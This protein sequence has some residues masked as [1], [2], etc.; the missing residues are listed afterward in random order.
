MSFVNNDKIATVLKK[1]IMS[2]NKENIETINFHLSQI[3]ETKN[4]NFSELRNFVS[5]GCVIVIKNFI[6]KSMRLEI[7]NKIYKIS[8]EWTS[9][10][11][12]ELHCIGSVWYCCAASNNE[13]DYFAYSQSNNA[14]LK[15]I[16]PEINESINS[17]CSLF[18]DMN[19]EIRE[20]WAGP[21]IIIL[22]E[23]AHV[24][25]Q[26]GP[27][28]IDW[29]NLCKEQICDL[30][31][32]K[33]FSFVMVLQKPQFGGNLIV[34]NKQY[35]FQIDGCIEVFDSVS[36][37]TEIQS[38]EIPYSEGSLII[39]NSLNLHAVQ[40]FSGS[41]DRICLIFHAAQFS[42]KWKIWI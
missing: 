30:N 26:G 4:N 29:D 10:F 5:K 35:N 19:V 18:F 42:G 39:F 23:N 24:A 31:K 16:F 7:I 32:S 27:I 2:K 17:F 37:P 41:K 1:M 3:Q 8:S 20:G 33:A 14:K 12:G 40:P 15:S 38:L 34:W 28:H 13:K 9:Y 36:C 11:N 6:S 21:A 22:Q 25:K